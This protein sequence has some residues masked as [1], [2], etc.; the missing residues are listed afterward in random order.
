MC[1]LSPME[2]SGR[3]NIDFADE[4][5]QFFSVQV[6]RY[7]GK[8]PSQRFTGLAEHD[9]VLSMIQDAWVELRASGQLENLSSAGR[10]AVY[11]TTIICFPTFVADAGLRCIP[12]DFIRGQRLGEE[13]IAVASRPI[14]GL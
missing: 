2:A 12:V 6:A 3:T 5:R 11:V 4:T 14:L 13:I 8:R 7:L 1:I 10:E 9:A